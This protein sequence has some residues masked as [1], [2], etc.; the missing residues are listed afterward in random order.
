MTHGKAGTTVLYV[1][2]R[3][4][5]LPQDSSSDQHLKGEQQDAAITGHALLPGTSRHQPALLRA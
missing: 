2:L 5:A 4:S 3:R 1:T